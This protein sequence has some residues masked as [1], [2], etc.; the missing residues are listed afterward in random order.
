MPKLPGFQPP[1]KFPGMLPQPKPEMGPG[2]LSQPRVTHGGTMLP[3]PMPPTGGGMLPQPP[4][5]RDLSGGILKAKAE[6]EVKREDDDGPIQVIQGKY[7]GQKGI[8]MGQY[9]DE[10]DVLLE[11]GRHRIKASDLELPKEQEGMFY[12]PEAVEKMLD[13]DYLS[14]D[15]RK[16]IEETRES[17]V[18]A[19]LAHLRS[20]HSM[21]GP[22]LEARID[23]VGSHVAKHYD[24]AVGR[25]NSEQKR[26]RSLAESG[27][28]LREMGHPA[29]KKPQDLPEDGKTGLREF[30][31]DEG[32]SLNVGKIARD[33]GGFLKDDSGG[34]IDEVAMNDIFEKV[35]G[36]SL[37]VGKKVWDNLSRFVADEDGLMRVDH[38]LLD[39]VEFFKPPDDEYK[40]IE[41]R[42]DLTFTN[43]YGNSAY[44]SLVDS[45]EKQ[46]AVLKPNEDSA[47]RNWVLSD[48]RPISNST[49][50]GQPN[51]E[52]IAMWSALQHAPF[53]VP[54]NLKAVRYMSDR[55]WKLTA[56]EVAEAK[57]GTGLVY[58][59]TWWSVAL[60]ES[61]GLKSNFTDTNEPGTRDKPRAIV[62]TFLQIPKGT[63]TL[64][65]SPDEYELILPPGSAFRITNLTNYEATDKWGQ[66]RP[67]YDV[68]LTL[69]GKH[70]KH[71]LAEY[72]FQPEPPSMLGRR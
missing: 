27:E 57:S 11:S 9:D 46:R 4:P 48:Y 23:A 68:Y 62:T 42:R 36:A 37:I 6:K 22:D 45:A 55:E 26:K 10:L 15:D 38:G 61:E 43:R 13:T 35:T 3:Q 56:P 53:A 72:Q 51:A 14:N 5:Q 1:P 34:T 44:W 60:E 17:D 40:W 2:I 65:G 52:S 24:S 67:H 69:V 41:D 20:E 29:G 71:A 32:G 21:K 63:E 31:Q 18:K 59:P 16:H 54:G 58:V 30:A 33:L 28:A 47:I 64:I 8:V 39:V 66:T 12:T 50:E 25:E 19:I 7:K 70:P 49:R